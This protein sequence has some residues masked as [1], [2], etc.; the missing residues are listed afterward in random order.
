MKKMIIIAVSLLSLSTLVTAQ[1][2]PKKMKHDKVV[3]MEGQKTPEQRAKKS[4][5]HLSTKITLTEDQ[6]AKITALALERAKKV[7]AIKAKYK[8]AEKDKEA[9]KTEIHATRKEYR[10]QLKALLTPEQLATLKEK[11]KAEKG[12]GMGKGKGLEKVKPEV[13]EGEEDGLMDVE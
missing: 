10:A 12:K 1:E 7:D 2:S 9:A 8:G 6:K 13:K 11:A 4:V 3:S 5:E